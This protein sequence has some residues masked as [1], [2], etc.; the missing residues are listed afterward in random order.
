MGAGSIKRQEK[1]ADKHR[2]AECRIE[3]QPQWRDRRRDGCSGEIMPRPG[4]DRS[5]QLQGQPESSR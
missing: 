3:K 1:D 5:G 4:A 2:R